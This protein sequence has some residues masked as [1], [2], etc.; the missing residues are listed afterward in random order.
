MVYPVAMWATGDAL[1]PSGIPQ[2][3]SGHE[4]MK[5]ATMNSCPRD[6]WVLYLAGGPSV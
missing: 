2:H 5:K 3:P 6:L 4:W 1:R